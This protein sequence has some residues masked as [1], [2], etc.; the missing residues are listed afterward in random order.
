MQSWLIAIIIIIVVIIIG[1]II[2][3]IYD[4]IRNRNSP[5]DLNDPCN[6]RASQPCQD[7][8]TCSGATG[9]CKSDIGSSCTTL[10]DCISTATSCGIPSGSTSTNKVCIGSSGGLNQPCPTGICNNGLTC[11]NNYCKS[12]PGN[13]C[14]NSSDCLSGTCNNNICSA[15]TLTVGSACGTPGNT[16]MSGLFCSNGFCQ[17]NGFTGGS[18][19]A[20]C[21]N[22][23]LTGLSCNNDLQCRYSVCVIPG[24]FNGACG[25]TIPCATP[26]ICNAT[27]G[28]CLYPDNPNTCSNYCSTG[29]T[30]SNGNCL[31]ASGTACFSGNQCSSGNCN[32]QRS[33]IYLPG[34]ATINIPPGVIFSRLI[35]GNNAGTFT[36]MSLQSNNSLNGLYVVSPNGSVTRLNN[37]GTFSTTD[38]SGNTMNYTLVD[39]SQNQDGK[40]IAIYSIVQTR[41]NMSTNLGNGLFSM[42]IN[43]L[44]SVTIV[45]FNTS[46][47]LVT[48]SGT[49]YNP[50][51]VDISSGLTYNV[52]ISA[53]VGTTGNSDIF[54]LPVGTQAWIQLPTS[55]SPS[56]SKLM[57]RYYNLTT[58]N[59]PANQVAYLINGSLYFAGT[60]S[61]ITYTSTSI[62]NYATTRTSDSLLSVLAVSTTG[63]NIYNLING[64]V[65][66]GSGTMINPIPGY[67]D[68]TSLVA[69]PQERNII[70]TTQGLCL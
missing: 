32:L 49:Q 59:S 23:G 12:N 17:F 70:Y 33:V 67:V 16:C 9:I 24:G 14:K 69:Y 68:S 41:N 65:G 31:G 11:Y 34:Q 44:N 64:Q 30:C 51:Q 6:T 62:T 46:N 25:A 58:T 27:R 47:G 29:Y 28:L 52:A 2:W 66:Y 7:G 39:F 45:P 8:L 35:P 15:G 42:T 56:G 57:P 18:T 21:V 50:I 26:L 54:V 20:Y 19:G 37:T 38:Q 48:I 3:F 36:G 4:Y 53:T 63:N 5:G 22:S 1:L 60:L 43:S 13:A 10:S 61:G 55:G 40:I